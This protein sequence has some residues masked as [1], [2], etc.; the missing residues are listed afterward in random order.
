[1]HDEQ[2]RLLLCIRLAVCIVKIR[3]IA[4]HCTARWWLTENVWFATTN[5]NTNSYSNPKMNLNTNYRAGHVHMAGHVCRHSQLRN[6]EGLEMMGKCQEN[7]WSRNRQNEKWWTVYNYSS[8]LR[9]FKDS[10]W[11]AWHGGKKSKVSIELQC[12]FHFY[13]CLILRYFGF[14]FYLSLKFCMLPRFR[15]GLP[16]HY[17]LYPAIARTTY[18]PL[19]Q[20]MANSSQLCLIKQNSSHDYRLWWVESQVLVLWH[21][22]IIEIQTLISTWPWVKCGC[23]KWWNTVANHNRNASN[24]KHTY[25]CTCHICIL[26]IAVILTHIAW[27]HI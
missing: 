26:P 9:A 16:M 25:M 13:C 19:L 3:I 21:E 22:Q 18:R 12:R 10:L 1:M 23:D 5:P 24:P 7:S 14:Q 6:A 20:S 15:K 27:C 2:R 4:Y 8:K 17:C 11:Q